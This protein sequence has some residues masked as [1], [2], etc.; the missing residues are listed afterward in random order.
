MPITSPTAKRRNNFICFVRHMQFHTPDL[1]LYRAFRLA[2]AFTYGELRDRFIPKWIAARHER[3]EFDS[4]YNVE[5]ADRLFVS[6]MSATEAEKRQAIRYEPI[7]SQQLIDALKMVPIKPT[8]FTFIDIGAGKGKVLFL[9]AEFAFKRI[10]GV[11]F[12]TYLARVI[13]NNISSYS[14]P[15]RQCDTIEVVNMN[16]LDFQLPTGSIILFFYFPFRA[17]LLAGVL[18]NF[19]NRLEDCLLIWITLED[20]EET[21][22]N[23]RPELTLLSRQ[24]EIP[25]YRG[26]N[27]LI[28]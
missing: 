24:G 4:K 7:E 8:E 9:A 18:N 16:A 6:E 10:I 25:I 2:A 14:N 5:T 23:S 20:A 28:P 12:D 13:E 3:I 22:I 19:G 17:P 21:V 1:G 11:E 15:E 27:I 26:S